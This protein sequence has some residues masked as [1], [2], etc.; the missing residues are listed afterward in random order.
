MEEKLV[1]ERVKED[2]QTPLV[3]GYEETFEHALEMKARWALSREEEE[4]VVICWE[5]EG[6]VGI[7]HQTTQMVWVLMTAAVSSMEGWACQ[8]Q[9]LSD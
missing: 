9:H 2:D 6:E 8:Y 7:D 1:R 3:P 4:E 5:E